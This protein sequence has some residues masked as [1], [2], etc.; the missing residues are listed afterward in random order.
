MAFPPGFLEE[1]KTRIAVSD[2][3]GRRVKLQKRGREYVGLSPF[4]SEKTPSFT[5]ND[6]KQFYHC[7]SSGEHGSIFDFLVKTEGLS[8]VE[9]VERLAGQAGLSMPQRDER[10]IQKFAAQKELIDVI[11]MAQAYFVE[12]LAM[13]KADAAR[14][15][16]EGRGIT[17]NLIKDF[18]IGFAPDRRD[19]LIHYLEQ[20]NISQTQML[21]A[22]LII[23]PEDKG[24]CYD[25]FRNRIMFPI[26]D[27]RARIIAFGGRALTRNTPA[28]YLNSPETELFHKGTIL[29][30]FAKARQPAY[31]AKTLLVCEGYMDVIGLARGGL[32]HAVASLGTAL[33]QEQIKLLWRLTP[34]PVLC[35]DGDMAGTQA[36]YRVVE[37]VLPLLQPGY[38]L[39]FALLPQGQDP[40]DIMRN[41]GLSAMQDCISRANSLV[42]ILWEREL[43]SAQYDTPERRAALKTRLRKT[44][45]LIR[46]RDI[47]ALYSADIKQRLDALFAPQAAPYRGKQAYYK[48]TSPV[49]PARGYAPTHEA[50]RSP[51]AT[52]MVNLPS[53]EVVLISYILDFPE[54]L[55]TQLEVFEKIEFSSLVLTHLQSDIITLYIEQGNL[56]KNQLTGLLEARGIDG[57]ITRIENIVKIHRPAEMPTDL[58]EVD[59]L[60]LDVVEFHYRAVALENEKRDAEKETSDWDLLTDKNNAWLHGL[61]EETG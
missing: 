50:K 41:S 36:A 23:K 57:L 58:K 29:Y 40:D 59:A 33:T 25:R 8:F 53:R 27:T 46:D 48:G 42:D 13:P 26:H 11:D 60:W 17:T 30:N 49:S 39:Q 52:N 45:S 12:N 16:L 4:K 47:R 14:H 61:A 35:F 7:F 31:E 6:D 56:D 18:G 54:L 5:V 19:G 28:K 2:V 34:E 1:I 3:V 21:A 20:K 32:Y 51:L 9:A 43:S 37:R 24:K 55:E 38:S 44:L 22:G 15:Y 10:Q